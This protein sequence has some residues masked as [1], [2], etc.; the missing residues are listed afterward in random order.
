MKK[1]LNLCVMSLAFLLVQSCDSGFDE[2]NTSKTNSETLDPIL[3][4]NNAIAN[5]APSGV[6]AGGTSP[7]SATSGLTYGLAISQQMISSNSGV[8][9]GGNFNQVNISNTPL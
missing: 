5:S 7:G 1:I 9:V 4:L 3:V 6:S 2:M 8:L